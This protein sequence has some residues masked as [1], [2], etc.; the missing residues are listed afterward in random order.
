[1]NVKA[2]TVLASDERNLA[3]TAVCA[4][5][6]DAKCHSSLQ[7]ARQEALAMMRWC[8]G[9]RLTDV[10]LEKENQQPRHQNPLPQL[11]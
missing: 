9:Q 10:H 3:P 7:S 11:Q 4:L 2:A 8:P 5:E 6:V 1:M